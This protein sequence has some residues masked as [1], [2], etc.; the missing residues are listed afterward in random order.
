MLN[1]RTATTE[2][3][4]TMSAGLLRVAKRTCSRISA[5]RSDCAKAV[6]RPPMIDA[7]PSGR[8]GAIP[9]RNV[10]HEYGQRQHA[11]RY[12]AVRKRSGP[13]TIADSHFGG[14]EPA[15]RGVPFRG[16]RTQ[17]RTGTGPARKNAAH[18]S[19]T[20]HRRCS[21]LKGNSWRVGGP[22]AQGV[23]AAAWCQSRSAAVCTSTSQRAAAVRLPA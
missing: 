6:R 14:R 17:R 20:P 19:A 18:A 5:S 4:N 16:G 8:D 1:S 11:P 15:P 12:S 22:R 13:A 7:A 3:P 2:A 23:I 9:P 21:L 10:L